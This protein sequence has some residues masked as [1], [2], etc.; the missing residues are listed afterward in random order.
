[1]ERRM[2]RYRKAFLIW[3]A[4]MIPLAIGLS[5]ASNTGT[6]STDSMDFAPKH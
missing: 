5:V 6:F 2:S 4:I 3:L 1:M